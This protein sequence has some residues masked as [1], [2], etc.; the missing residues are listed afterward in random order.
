MVRFIRMCR[1]LSI[2][3]EEIIRRITRLPAEIYSL[4]QRGMIAPGMKADLTI[5]QEHALADHA[6]FT[7]PHAPCSGI[8]DLY[9]N[10]TAHSSG[11]RAGKVIRVR[12]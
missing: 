6:D 9:I 7:A 8:F 10:G 4:K 12:K 5:F 3:M 11:I 1:D 2:P